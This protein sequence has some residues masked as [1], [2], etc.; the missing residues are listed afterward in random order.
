MANDTIVEHRSA[1]EVLNT[2]GDGWWSL[3]EK[4]VKITGL[5]V[6]RSAERALF[7]ELRVFFDAATWDI[8]K[9]GYIYTDKGFLKEL[10]DYLKRAGYAS[11]FGTVGYSEFGMQGDNFVSL[12]VGAAFIKSWSK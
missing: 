12:D 4:A 10:R 1:D 7:G 8:E 3:Q 9:D 5:E 11:G 2:S 6:N